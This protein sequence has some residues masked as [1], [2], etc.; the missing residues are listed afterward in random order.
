MRDEHNPHVHDVIGVGVGPFN[1]GLA[2]LAEPIT[3]LDALFLDENQTFDWHPGLL[4][5]GATLQTP[6]LA[7]LVT[8]ADPTS[9]FS[10]L[11]Y[12]KAT[13]RIYAFYIR[14]QFSILRAEYNQY[15]RWVVEQL[16]SVIFDRRVTA[17]HYEAHRGCY[18]VETQQLSS[19]RCHVYY[20]RRLV[21]GTGPSR[22]VPACCLGEG[23]G[24]LHAADYVAHRD[25][26]AAASNVAIVGSGQSAAEIFQDRLHYAGDAQRLDWFTRSPRFFA[27]AYD[28]LTLELTSPE[29]IDY[30]HELSEHKRDQ[31]SKAH[32]PLYKGID[33]DLSAMIYDT[34][35]EKNVYG[36]A[37]VG[38]QT[39]ASLEEV[40]RDA[41]GRLVLTFI[42]SEQGRWFSHTCDA[43]I[44]ATGF[45]HRTPD[46]IEPIVDRLRWDGSQRFAVTR[47]YAIDHDACDIF[48]QNAE[49][50]TH[51]FTASDLGMACYRNA[52]ILR[53]LLGREVYSVERSIAFQSFDARNYPAP[54]TGVVAANK[55]ES[56]HE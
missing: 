45:A 7:D 41:E 55:A 2:A 6:F 10:F 35:Y 52:V 28:K 54:Q 53:E 48:V 16:E 23:E 18:R 39:N 33:R 30:F 27:M 21:L 5:E 43:L 32:K 15:C 46:Y 17:I 51:G 12:L 36:S 56:I 38:M 25:E 34:L 1:L 8:L 4:L 50:H 24:V 26:L 9:R 47:N 13:G 49:L 14:E 31:L 3:E 22:Y 37:N 11:N 29:Y 19:G 20:G 44:L 42:Q 40:S